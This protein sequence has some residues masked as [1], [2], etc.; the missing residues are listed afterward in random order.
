MKPTKISKNKNGKGKR[1]A[2]K[3]AV[4]IKRISPAKRFPKSRMAKESVRTNSA[5]PS[6]IPTKNKMGFLRLRY[7]LK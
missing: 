2:N 4:I 5:N 3:K 6:K 7:F 1:K